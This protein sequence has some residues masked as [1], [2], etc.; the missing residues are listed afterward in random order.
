[1]KENVFA[2]YGISCKI[3]YTFINTKNV[4]LWKCSYGS[5]IELFTLQKP[6]R[7]CSVDGT[8]DKV[9]AKTNFYTCKNQINA[10]FKN[11]NDE[12]SGY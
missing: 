9:P 6:I 10:N 7:I 11:Y 12:R 8:A 2:L 3:W 5:L 1:M 4:N